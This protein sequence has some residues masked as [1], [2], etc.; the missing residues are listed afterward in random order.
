[1]TRDNLE[2]RARSL[3]ERRHALRQKQMSCN[4]RFPAGTSVIV[5]AG[6][7]SVLYRGQVMLAVDIQGQVQSPLSDEGLLNLVQTLEGV[8]NPETAKA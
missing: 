7:L 8:L 3:A 1:M 4:S 6:G 2:N 5:E